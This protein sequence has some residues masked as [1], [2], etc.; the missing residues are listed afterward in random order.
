M[1]PSTPSPRDTE[2]SC[3]RGWEAPTPA[4]WPRP[5][6]RTCR[7]VPLV[8][9]RSRAALR[10][11][12]PCL[13]VPGAAAW[14]PPPCPPGPCPRL[15]FR[16]SPPATCFR[17]RQ[18]PDG[19]RLD[20]V[21]HAY[22]VVMRVCRLLLIWPDGEISQGGVGVQCVSGPPDRGVAR[23]STCRA[24]VAGFQDMVVTGT[25]PTHAPPR[26]TM[27]PSP[28]EILTAACKVPV[29]FPSRGHD[30][31]GQGPSPSVP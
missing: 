10:P 9:P 26:C 22:C 27:T 19:R 21:T 12:R 31:R 20:G 28:R 14:M 30:P 29:S 1:Q 8:T 5:C 4:C 2:S 24:R 17:V 13:P 11:A 18:E 25:A 3:E 15:L 6:S 7:P 23:M 16:S